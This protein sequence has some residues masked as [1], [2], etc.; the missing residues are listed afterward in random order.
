MLAP[1]LCKWKLLYLIYLQRQPCCGSLSESLKWAS[2]SNNL[3]SEALPSCCG[4]EAIQGYAG[5]YLIPHEAVILRA[6]D[7]DH[8]L[9]GLS[10]MATCSA[11]VIMPSL[12]RPC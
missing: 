4:R 9:T 3:Q 1:A 12:Y 10:S 11:S 8:T 2:H 7:T 6:F 5:H